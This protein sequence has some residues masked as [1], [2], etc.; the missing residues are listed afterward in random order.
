MLIACYIMH[1]TL[2]AK[3]LGNYAH[4]RGIMLV[5][6]MVWRFAVTCSERQG[7]RTII[8]MLDSELRPPPNQCSSMSVIDITSDD[9]TVR[10]ELMGLHMSS[11]EKQPVQLKPTP[12]QLL[13]AAK[14]ITTDD[15]QRMQEEQKASESNKQEDERKRLMSLTDGFF[16]SSLKR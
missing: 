7:Q 10:G 15:Y 12:G 5:S 11:P 16:F 2:Y 13:E 4:R 8:Y 14:I 6:E 1:I 3:L 9:G